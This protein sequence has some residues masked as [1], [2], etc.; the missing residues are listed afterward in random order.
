M[1]A[2]SL[3][4]THG[5]PFLLSALLVVGLLLTFHTPPAPVLASSDPGPRTIVA[6]GTGVVPIGYQGILFV[7]LEARA[8]D[9]ESATED[10]LRLE[11][12]AESALAEVGV[13]AGDIQHGTLQVL[14]E[15]TASTDGFVARR[16]LRVTV[17]G[18]QEAAPVIRA[19][20]RAG[21]A[22]TSSVG[23]QPLRPTATEQQTALARALQDARGQAQLLAKALGV[24]LGPASEVTVLG[25]G[26][27]TDRDGHPLLKIT[28][29]VRYG[30]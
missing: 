30:S 12:K 20:L 23:W 14:P 22:A 3:V 7:T 5:V 29:Q 24:P 1:E 26:L 10:V 17:D 9:G 18:L 13:E 27:Q 15:R 8:K 19:A 2:D 16:V 25:D 28:V 6:T 4:K 11:R 21:A